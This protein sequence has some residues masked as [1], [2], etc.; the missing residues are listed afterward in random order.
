[1]F[2]SLIELNLWISITL[3]IIYLLNLYFMSEEINF[4]LVSVEQ[5]WTSEFTSIYQLMQIDLQNQTNQLP[6]LLQD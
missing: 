2:N 1:M 4:I 6:Q 5:L 3:I